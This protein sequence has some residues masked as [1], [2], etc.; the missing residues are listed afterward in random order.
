[1]AESKSRGVIQVASNDV[2]EINRALAMLTQWI[3]EL[4]GLRG[5]ITLYD[6]VQ[7]QDTNAE[8]LHGFGNPTG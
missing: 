4:T 5:A 7:Y 6:T 3:D 1:M 8:K 2:A